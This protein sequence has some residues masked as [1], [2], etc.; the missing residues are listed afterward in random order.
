MKR[1]S[2]VIGVA[3]SVGLAACGGVGNLKTRAAFDM[4]C[5]E[6]SLQLTELGA[7]SYGVEGCGQRQVYVC[8]QQTSASQCDDWV[9]NSV[10]APTPK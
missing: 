6:E 8:K 1:T 9:L 3:L 5:K 2:L 4:K 7:A 10:E